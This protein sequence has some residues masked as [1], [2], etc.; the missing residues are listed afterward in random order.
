MAENIAI[1]EALQ[2]LV[3]TYL[4]H[5]LIERGLSDNTLAAYRRDLN[6]YLH[7]LALERVD[8]VEQITMHHVAG[9]LQAL[10][11]GSHNMGQLANSSV[12]R[13]IVAARGWHRFMFL[14]NTT[15]V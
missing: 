11:S 14:E 4:N 8:N 15:D 12:N 10:S 13:I 6:R 7:Y 1:P 3:T 9:F 2:R 5:L